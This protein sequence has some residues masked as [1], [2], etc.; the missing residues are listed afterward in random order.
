MHIDKPALTV[1]GLCYRLILTIKLK[2]EIKFTGGGVL[3]GV[4]DYK[5]LIL[6]D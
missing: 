2:I 6:S 1:C 4:R 3:P 5:G